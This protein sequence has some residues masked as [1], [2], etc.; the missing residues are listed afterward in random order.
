MVYIKVKNNFNLFLFL[1]VQLW[2]LLKK[3]E[4]KYKKSSGEERGIG[5]KEGRRYENVIEM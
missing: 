5:G 1:Q 4:K 3:L 2:N